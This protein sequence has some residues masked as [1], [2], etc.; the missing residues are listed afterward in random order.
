MRNFYCDGISFSDIPDQRDYLH[1]IYDGHFQ[2]GP[3]LGQY[4]G[5]GLW[6]ERYNGKPST[7]SSPALFLIKTKQLWPIRCVYRIPLSVAYTQLVQS[8]Q[9]KPD[10]LLHQFAKM[11][12]TLCAYHLPPSLQLS[13]F[14]SY[15]AGFLTRSLTFHALL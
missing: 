5:R 11:H 1:V 9:I 13:L 4:F 15:S 3:I 12:K 6:T 14:P 2:M 8:Q 7:F 10:F